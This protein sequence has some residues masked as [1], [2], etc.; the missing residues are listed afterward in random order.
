ML[1]AQHS[2]TTEGQQPKNRLLIATHMDYS[3]ILE[4]LESLANPKAIA[5]MARYGIT[6]GK[7]YGVSIPHLRAIARAVGT[8][9][10]LA[11]W[12]WRNGSRETRILASM[13]ADPRLLT[14]SEMERWAAEFTYWEIC[15]QCCMNLFGRMPLAWK[16]AIEWSSR[17]EE[18]FKRAAFVLM[19]RLAV[20]EKKAPDERF[21]PF[22]PIIAAAATDE[23]NM[24]KKA[25]NWA[26]RQIGK[27]SP[28]L[29]A[30]AIETAGK[31]QQMD[32]KSAR[33]I[34]A[35][36]LRELRSAPVR[37]RFHSPRNPSPTAHLTDTPIHPPP[38]RG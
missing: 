32:S 2:P 29:N 34:A 33:W 10:E 3:E 25:V 20:S 31:I 5:G 18:S 27:R 8:N 17:P 30:R 35:E 16:K 1:G 9:H 13:I 38:N 26:L 15:D 36:A 11:Q 19:A 37:R 28:A 21:E 12:L 23:R 22:L 24:V 6:P 4:H 7:A 14:E